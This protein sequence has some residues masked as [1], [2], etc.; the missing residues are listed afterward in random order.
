MLVS[1]G[2][3]EITAGWP[4]AAPIG[5]A[6][7]TRTAGRH[8]GYLGNVGEVL[9]GCLVDIGLRWRGTRGRELRHVD[10][11]FYF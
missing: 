5:M 4:A 9:P 11:S 7:R 10:P 6:G 1:A 3:S 8:A 2:T